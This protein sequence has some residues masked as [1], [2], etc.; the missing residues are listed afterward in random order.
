MKSLLKWLG[1]PFLRF[2]FGVNLVDQRTGLVIGRVAVVR[3]KGGLRLFGLDDAA[4]RPH[5]L[6]QERERYWSQDLGFSTHAPPDFPHVENRYSA[7]L[8]PDAARGGG[9]DGG[10]GASES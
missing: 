10:V 2:F 5:F 6:V 8:P 1:L 3:W 9:D 4:V 7:D